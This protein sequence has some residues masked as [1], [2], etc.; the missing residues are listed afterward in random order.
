MTQQKTVKHIL[1]H[2]LIIMDKSEL[3]YSAQKGLI[4]AY[5]CTVNTSVSH[6]L[7]LSD[8]VGNFLIIYLIFVQND[9]DLT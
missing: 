1:W 9:D 7:V 5:D 2:K 4:A 6:I 8:R 3:G